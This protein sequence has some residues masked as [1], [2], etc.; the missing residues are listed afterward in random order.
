MEIKISN[1]DKSA[2]LGN[3]DVFSFVK[4]TFPENHVKRLSEIR[5]VDEYYSLV[6]NDR[7]L[8]SLLASG[9]N[10]TSRWFKTMTGQE[11]IE[12]FRQDVGG[13]I[14]VERLKRDIAHEIGHSVYDNMSEAERFYYKNIWESTKAKS[15]D[16]RALNN[17]EEDF[18]FAY[19][20]YFTNPIK[21]LDTIPSKYEFVQKISGE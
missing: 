12:I 8:E 19:S 9:L 5:Y 3:S 16:T 13:N 14:D 21:L 2:L 11:I 4:I 20:L 15:S 7:P 10:V 17:Q 6:S 18:C 1:F